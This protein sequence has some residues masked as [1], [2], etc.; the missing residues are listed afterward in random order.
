MFLCALLVLVFF[1]N[2]VSLD[3][4]SLCALYTPPRDTVCQV[5]FK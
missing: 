2:S 3:S 1:Y 4:Q 5:K